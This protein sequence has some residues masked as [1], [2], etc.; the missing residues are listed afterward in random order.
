MQRYLHRPHLLDGYKYDLRLYVLLSSLNPLRIFI[1][2]EGLVRVC[3]QKYHAVE[4]N[5][6]DVRMHLTNYA[7]N[8]DSE[9]F[10]Q[11][12]DEEDCDDAHKRTISSLMRTLADEAMQ[13]WEALKQQPMLIQQLTALDAKLSGV[14]DGL[15]AKIHEKFTRTDKQAAQQGQEMITNLRPCTTART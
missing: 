3:T 10:V 8:K 2:R 4:K 15:F 11:P 12:E 7:I 1:F 9:A 6:S 5:M 14:H 13:H